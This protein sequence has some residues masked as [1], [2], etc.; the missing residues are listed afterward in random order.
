MKELYQAK[1]PLEAQLLKDY[2]ASYHIDTLIQ[3]EYLTGAAGDLP[4]LQFPLLWVT[5]DRDVERARQLIDHFFT[6]ESGSAPWHC[7]QCHEINE[8]QF[9]LCWHCGGARR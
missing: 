1:D 8:G 9:Q 3:G 2:L 7:T 4:A 5:D 6:Q